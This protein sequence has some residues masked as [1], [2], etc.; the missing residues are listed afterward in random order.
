M[1]SHTMSRAT[2]SQVMGS[3]VLEKQ[4]HPIG[5]SLIRVIEMTAVKR[6]SIIAIMATADFERMPATSSMPQMSSVQDIMTARLLTAQ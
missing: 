3:S 6:A 4:P 1:A 2:V 5:I